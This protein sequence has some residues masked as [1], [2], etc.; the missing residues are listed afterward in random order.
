MSANCGFRRQ[1][2][3]LIDFSG[4]ANLRVGIRGSGLRHDKLKIML[5]K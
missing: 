3:N 2:D 5:Y 1:S 4:N